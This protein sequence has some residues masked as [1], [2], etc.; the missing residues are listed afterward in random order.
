MIYSISELEAYLA[1]VYQGRTLAI[2]PYWY[3]ITFSA[4]TQA[5][6]SSQV[7]NI[8]ANAD[9]HCIGIRH[10]ANSGTLQTVSDKTAP[11]GRLLITD[12]GTSQTL[13]NSAVDLENFSQNDAKQQYFPY[14]RLMAGKSSQTLT[15]TCY[16]PAAETISVDITLVGVLVQAY[17]DAQP[18]LMQPQGY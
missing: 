7:I 5:A 17:G 13:M 3:T 16:A 6:A 1:R 10:R 9:F 11:F 14:P 18:M 2:L 4:L 12:S 8:Q 15:L